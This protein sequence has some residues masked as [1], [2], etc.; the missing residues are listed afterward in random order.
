MII[1]FCIYI[2]VLV[3]V[4]ININTFILFYSFYKHITIGTYPKNI[5]LNQKI[6]FS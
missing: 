3:Y 6:S 2:Y 4:L 5:V 1:T